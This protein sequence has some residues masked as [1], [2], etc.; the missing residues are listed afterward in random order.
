[1][2]FLLDAYAGLMVRGIEAV[3]RF[4]PASEGEAPVP[5]FLY[6]DYEWQGKHFCDNC[7]HRTKH[8][9]VEWLPEHVITA[10]CRA[11]SFEGTLP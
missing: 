6:R 3:R 10:T 7:E 1:M 2:R 9:F 11:C 4:F 8:D 5:N